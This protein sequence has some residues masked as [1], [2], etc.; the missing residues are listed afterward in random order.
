MEAEAILRIMV[1][2]ISLILS[3]IVLIE[4]QTT[5]RRYPTLKVWGVFLLLLG[6]AQLAAYPTKPYVE[7]TPVIPREVAR[8]IE[9]VT[10][11]ICEGLFLLG[12]LMIITEKKEYYAV[13]AIL[14]ALILLTRLMDKIFISNVFS[15]ITA[16]LVT[17]I[18]LYGYKIVRSTKAILMAV[19]AILWSSGVII[20]MINL[21]PG[22]SIISLGLLVLGY[23]ILM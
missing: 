18:F 11:S 5:R 2:T 19:A 23:A 22:L 6:V 9:I 17:G 15:S 20:L 12:A 8:F 1:A 3:G 7:L 13:P 4:Y 14:T 16:A 21:I 10:S